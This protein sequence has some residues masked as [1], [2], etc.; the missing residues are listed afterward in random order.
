MTPNRTGHIGR[1]LRNGATALA[2]LGLVAAACG[3]VAIHSR[4]D[5]DVVVIAAAAAPFLLAAGAVAAALALL[6]RRRVLAL[7]CVLVV[8]A[9]TWTYLPLFRAS[10]LPA[11]RA[12]APTI[13][14]LQ[15]NITVGGADPVAL[16][17]LARD[18]NIDIATV[19]ELTDDAVIALREAGFEEQ[20]EHRLLDPYPTGGGGSGIYSRLPLTSGGPIEGMTLS[21]LRADVDT[22]TGTPL[23]LYAVHPLPGFLAPARLWAADLVTLRRVLESPENSGAVVVSGDFNAT[24]SHRRFRDLLDAGYAEA[25]DS[26]GAGLVPTYPTDKRIPALIGID[27]ILT[28]GA[29]ATS[30]ERVTIPN[31]DHHGLIADIALIGS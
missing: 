13:R 21:N 18:R 23:T 9:G 11:D 19:Q 30:L 5:H 15:T 1:L 6:T 29:T 17:A 22:G 12:D 31:A 25:A 24:R 3:L 16:T 28:R 27:H 10:P 4:F 20:F 7:L 8:A 26:T 2:V 14:L